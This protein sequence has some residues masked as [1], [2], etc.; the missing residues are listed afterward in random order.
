MEVFRSEVS[1]GF[2]DTFKGL[3]E[4]TEE[5]LVHFL[6]FFRREFLPRKYHYVKE[7]QVT[8]QKAYLNSGCSRTYTIDEKGKEHILFFAFEDWWLGDIES[9]HTGSPGKLNV[10]A[11]ED[12]ELLVITKKDFDYVQLNDIP[13]LQRWDELKQKKNL[14]ATLNRLAEVKTLSPEERYLK[15]LDKHPAIFQRIPLQYIASYLDIEPQSLS[16]M[17]KRLTAAH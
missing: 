7:G 15:L 14:F 3:L 12:C 5:E 2:V 1:A 4:L 8:R 11:M 6:T 10:Q 17:R 16:R 13:K 9:Y